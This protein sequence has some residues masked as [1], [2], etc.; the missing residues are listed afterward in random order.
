LEDFSLARIYPAATFQAT[1]EGKLVEPKS[2]L[3]EKAEIRIGGRVLDWLH[4]MRYLALVLALLLAVALVA[5][6]LIV[7]QMM[8]LGFSLL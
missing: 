6:A 1:W 4:G 2:V 8:D 5:L 7:S 3:K